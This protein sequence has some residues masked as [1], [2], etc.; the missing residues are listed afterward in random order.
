M[1]DMKT[2]TEHRREPY[3]K[4]WKITDKTDLDNYEKAL[5]DRLEGW[6]KQLQDGG[7]DMLPVAYEKLVEHI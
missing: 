7:S 2:I 6:E 4:Q 1:K 3:K 5:G